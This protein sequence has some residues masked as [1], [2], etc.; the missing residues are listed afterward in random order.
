MLFVLNLNV[1]L[2]NSNVFP[3]R[4][5]LDRVS[6]PEYKDQTGFQ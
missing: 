3:W 2:D 5:V 6:V 4:Y 1:I